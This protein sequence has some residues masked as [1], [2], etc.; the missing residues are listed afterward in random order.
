MGMSRFVSFVMTKG[1][2]ATLCTI[3]LLLIISLTFVRQATKSQ[4]AKCKHK[5]KITKSGECNMHFSGG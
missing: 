3:L 1:Q 4:N 2:L 5:M